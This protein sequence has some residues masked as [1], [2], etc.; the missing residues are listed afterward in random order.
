[1]NL[2]TALPDVI[3]SPALTA[4]WKNALEQVE[5]GELPD[6]AFMDGIKAPAS[7]L[8]PEHTANTRRCLPKRQA[9]K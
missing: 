8:I 2:T 5:R 7:G 3:K 1:M 4:E 6:T 9:A